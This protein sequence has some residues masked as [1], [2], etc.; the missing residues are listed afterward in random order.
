MGCNNYYFIPIGILKLFEIIFLAIA[1]ATVE[2]VYSNASIS[3][4]PSGI[5]F[6]L[7]VCT[8]TFAVCVLW[9]ILNLFINIIYNKCFKI[10]VA[11]IHLI[12]GIVVMVGAALLL[13]KV[14]SVDGFAMLKTGG[15][16]GVIAAVLLIIEG[17]LHF[18]IKQYYSADEARTELKKDE[19][20]EPK[21]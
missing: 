9:F 4:R 6:H 15:A 11:V 5:N 14:A 8:F 7:G 20:A 21:V 3:L 1:F 13:S 10:I 19:E 16:F 2:S 12:L 18:C 17:L